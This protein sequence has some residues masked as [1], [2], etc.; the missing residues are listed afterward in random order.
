MVVIVLSSLDWPGDQSV[1]FQMVFEV[2]NENNKTLVSLL[3]TFL[4]VFGYLVLWD[5]DILY[6]HLAIWEKDKLCWHL[7]LDSK[8]KLWRIESNQKF[9]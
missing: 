9:L 8:I 6:W 4:L 5:K 7:V 3:L 2:K 1:S